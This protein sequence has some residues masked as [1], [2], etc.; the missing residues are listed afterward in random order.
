MSSLYITFMNF[1]SIY[2]SITL[3]LT[4]IVAPV[5]FYTVLTKS[6]KIGKFKWIILN[7][8]FWSFLL[9]IIIGVVKP[10]LLC[11]SAAGFSVGLLRNYSYKLSLLSALIFLICSVMSIFG[12]SIAI[13]SRYLFIFPSKLKSMLQRKESFIAIII[14]HLICILIS[15]AVMIP[16]F[17]ITRKKLYYSCRG[18]NR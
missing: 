5:F 3:S 12:L 11:P 2:S 13:V 15:F 8:S 6:S 14:V 7:H 17:E 4:L 9:E 1:Y 16:T 18:C 10:V